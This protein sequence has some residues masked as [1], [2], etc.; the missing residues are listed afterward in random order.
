LEIGAGSRL[1]NQII[2]M[3]RNVRIAINPEVCSTEI[4][5]SYLVSLICGIR[6]RELPP[7]LTED[8][9]RSSAAV[10]R[11]LACLRLYSKKA[12]NSKTSAGLVEWKI[13]KV[14]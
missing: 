9:K 11:L 7:D 13:G 12:G 2:S 8:M 6:N 5:T 3:T 10:M 4:A 1:D 14:S